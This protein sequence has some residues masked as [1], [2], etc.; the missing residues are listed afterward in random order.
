MNVLKQ[1]SFEIPTNLKVLEQVL[2]NFN[3]LNQPWIAQKDWLEC[4]LALAEGFTNAVRHAHSNFPPE[5]P[6]KIDITL[7]QQSLE[8]RIIDCGP[9]FDLKGFLQ[10]TQ[11]R[12]HQLSSHGQG[13]P[14]LQKISDHLSYCRIDDH[15]NCL[16]IVKKFSTPDSNLN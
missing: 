14:I 16:L 4:K 5:T 3:Q 12:D 1:I 9:P 2:E 8:I 6:I 11:N 15:H 10:D 13:L 7:N